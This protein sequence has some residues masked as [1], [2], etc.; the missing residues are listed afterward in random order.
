MSSKD[1]NTETKVEIDNNKHHL[2]SSDPDLKVILG[3]GE[4]Q[5]TKWYY[6]TS[7]AN[8]S[9]Y[10]DTMLSTPMKE[11]DTRTITFPDITLEF[12]EAAIDFVDN[13][14]A[15]RKME[16]S[17]V[18]NVAKFYDKYEFVDGTNLCDCVLLDYFKHLKVKEKE[19]SIDVDLLI[20]SV[21]ISHETNLKKAVEAGVHYIWGILR[22]P[23]DP[24]YNKTMFT[25][26]HLEKVLP[27]MLH[28]LSDAAF[29]DGGPLYNPGYPYPNLD[30]PDF[31]KEFVKVSIQQT[32]EAL[33]HSCIKHIKL[34]DAECVVND[35]SYNIGG[36][37]KKDELIS[38][39]CFEYFNTGGMVDFKIKRMH[40]VDDE[41]PFEF[42]GWAIIVL[43]NEVEEICWVAP[44][45]AALN[46][47][48]KS[49][50]KKFK[51]TDSFFAYKK[52]KHPAPTIT[53]V[54]NKEA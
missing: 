34:S 25:E 39:R 48:P 45:S 38:G 1:T 17:D 53:Y 44:C 22:L 14:V 24:P 41:V 8:K 36:T 54:L 15:A 33:L 18:L 49:G 16:A 28:E 27:A 20:D 30:D 35:R 32:E 10:I 46:F 9:K 11:S 40:Y 2:R 23:M 52:E 13:P 42:E 29:P 37:C 5:V 26:S 31:P 12:W 47:P 43:I 51:K 6:A 50:W 3:S 7:L 19:L 21:V 4:D